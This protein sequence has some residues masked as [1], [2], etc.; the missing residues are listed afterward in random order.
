MRWGPYPATGYTGT[1]PI[2]NSTDL[3]EYEDFI[4]KID[5]DILMLWGEVPF[6]Y[7]PE[8]HNKASDPNSHIRDIEQR[9]QS[10]EMEV[11]CIETYNQHHQR[12]MRQITRSLLTELADLRTI[13][14]ILSNNLRTEAIRSMIAKLNSDILADAKY[15]LEIRNNNT[16]DKG[17]NG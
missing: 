3:Q 8:L 12:E 14:D 9:L 4:K 16:M 11:Q 13:Q 2:R 10:I 17:G 5:I 15:Q 6:S 1:W 7:D